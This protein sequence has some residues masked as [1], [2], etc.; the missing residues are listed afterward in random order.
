MSSIASSRAFRTGRA[1]RVA[2]FTPVLGLCVAF[3]LGSPGALFVGP[4]ELLG[5]PFGAVLESVALLWMAIGVAA[6]WSARSPVTEALVHL[7]FTVPATTLAVF[8][9]SLIEIMRNL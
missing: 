8:A 3:I 2:A 1:S 6:I 4:P 9:P 5:I 7:V